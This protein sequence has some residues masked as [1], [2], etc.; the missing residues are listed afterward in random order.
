MD[1][2]LNKFVYRTDIAIWMFVTGAL[3]A[4]VIA[5]I[6]VGMITIKA[7]RTNPSESLKYE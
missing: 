2:W 3:L 1:K 7:A 4:L 6:T 5:I